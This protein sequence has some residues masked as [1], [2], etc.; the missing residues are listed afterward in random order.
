LEEKKLSTLTV[1]WCT[2]TDPE[3]AHVGLYEKDAEKRGIPVDTFFID[4]NQVDRAIVDGEEGFVKIHVK[5]GTDRILALLLSP[6]MLE[7]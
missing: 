7:K 4:F 5:R 1:P 6:A 3:I 2:Y